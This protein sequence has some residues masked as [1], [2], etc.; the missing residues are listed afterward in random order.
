MAAL[1]DRWSDRRTE[2]RVAA[3]RLRWRAECGTEARAAGGAAQHQQPRRAGGIQ[4]AAAARRAH[5]A[6]AAWRRRPDDH[7]RTSRSLSRGGARAASLPRRADLRPSPRI[8]TMAVAVVSSNCAPAR[9][10]RDF[11][12]T[13]YS[14]N[15]RPKTNDRKFRP[16]FNATVVRAAGI[17]FV[18]RPRTPGRNSMDASGP[19]T[20]TAHKPAAVPIGAP[21]SRL[22]SGASPRTC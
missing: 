14:Q 12:G 17:P 3:E 15:R 19:T 21:A 16:E 9:A 20:T 5:R 7:S 18:S 10:V 11:V 2:Q 22:S 6:A 13:N 4:C 1:T 8:E